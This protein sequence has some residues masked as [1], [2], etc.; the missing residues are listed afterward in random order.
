MR[1]RRR[2]A[3]GEECRLVSTYFVQIGQRPYAEPAGPD[4][5]PFTLPK[6]WEAQARTAELIPDSGLVVINDI[7]EL[8]LHPRNKKDVGHRLALMALAKTYGRT[9]LVYSGP[10]FK[11]LKAEGKPRA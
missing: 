11:S 1:R 7:S 6:F 9:D 8:D 2:I 3:R 5:K 10:V 4:A